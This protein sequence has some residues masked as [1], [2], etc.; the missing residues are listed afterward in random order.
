[1]DDLLTHVPLAARLPGGVQGHRAQGPVQTMD[2]LETMLDL[3]G[4][5]TTFVRHAVSLVPQ[6][7][8]G[9]NGDLARVVYSEGGFSYVNEQM[10][11]ANECLKGGPAQVYYPRGLEESQ[12]N[13]SPR[14]V[15]LRNL[16]TKLVY[17]PTGECVGRLE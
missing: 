13:G 14:A 2:V 5:N 4:I 17:R 9:A 6:L 3:A 15:M 11:D 7:R 10:V 16:T 1:M 12:P 8:Q